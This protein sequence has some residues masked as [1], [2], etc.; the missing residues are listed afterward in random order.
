MHK[1]TIAIAALFC[2]NGFASTAALAA[3]LA[4]PPGCDIVS[5]RA[6]APTILKALTPAFPP[7]A[8]QMRTPVEPTAFASDGRTFLVYE[9]HFQ[10][11]S[12]APMTLR[13]IDVINSDSTVPKPVAAFGEA[14]LNAV[15]R[16]I[17]ADDL[18][19][20]MHPSGDENRRIGAGRSAVAFI[21]LAFD[22]D[23]P[24]PGK[25]RHRVQLDNAVT[26]GP[27]IG[28]HGSTLHV[29]SRP[30]VGTG[31]SA[32]NGPGIDSHHRT[33]L[34]V[35]GGSARISRRFA[36]DWKKYREGAAFSGDARDV[37]SYFSY[38]AKV[39]AVADGVIVLAKDGLPDN[40]PR[41]ADGFT[42]ALPITMD[43]IAGNCVIIDL[44]GGQ[45]ASYYHLQPGSVRV[46]TGERVRR[47]AP[48]ARIGN[49]GDARWPHLHFQVTDS[50]DVLASEGLP[51]VFDH[52]RIKVADTDWQ[53][54]TGE[55]PATPSAVMDFGA[56][57]AGAHE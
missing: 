25:L 35:A 16:P 46:T 3:D 22:G 28:T 53:M 10:N 5:K 11:Y 24:V 12:N 52:Y 39:L 34:M 32:D 36:L 42:P 37:R 18:Q 15:L 9:L 27:V 31:W 14:Q 40:V 41:T 56:D 50:P 20:H 47:G 26:D 33:G 19:Y 57:P 23:A 51:Y 1:H 43:N 48:I 8:L 30:L 38:G 55:F 7:V 45:F 29:L 49:S 21:C 13:G 4:P 54:R 44:G 2:W 6:G 17:G